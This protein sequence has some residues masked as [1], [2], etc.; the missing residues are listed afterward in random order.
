MAKSANKL[1]ETISQIKAKISAKIFPPNSKMP[2]EEIL[3]ESLGVS[4]STIRK[5]Y[6]ELKN[7]GYIN[8]IQNKGAF[9]CSTLPFREKI[10]I[11]FITA[12]GENTGRFFELYQGIQDY[13]KD[14]EFHIS[15]S[16]TGYS[17][18][19]EKEIVSDFISKGHN[20]LLIMGGWDKYNSNFYYSLIRNN[21]KIVFIDEKPSG[22]PCNYVACD[23]FDGGYQATEY[24]IKMGYKK[25]VFASRI[26]IANS[27]TTKQRF[28]GYQ[29]ALSDYNIKPSEKMVYELLDGPLEKSYNLL[30]KIFPKDTAFFCANDELALPLTHHFRSNGYNHPVVGFDNIKPMVSSSIPTASV[31]QPFYD[32]GY[33]AAELLH[34]SILDPHLPITRLELPV[35]LCINK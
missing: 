25:I 29:Q 10:L 32:I 6:A 8:I 33:K 21:I 20:H 7:D 22:I 30:L 11:P 35:K 3:A 12:Y 2:S 34:K 17:P 26:A 4:R 15:F 9:V 5:A 28:F 13:F 16:I 19:K 1:K 14:T 27:T 24:L 31:D 23:N 18:E